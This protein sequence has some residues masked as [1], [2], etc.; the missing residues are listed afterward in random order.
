M[1]KL[2]LLRVSKSFSEVRALS[3]VSLE[4][5]SGEVHALMGENGAGKS[6]LIKI[7][8]GVLP[9]DKISI[10]VDGNLKVINSFSDSKK[11]GF[12]FIHQ[13]LNV[14]PH[15]SV[16]ENM[17]LSMHYPMMYNVFIN[18][19]R[20]H[21]SANEALNAL[22][23][24]HINTK[25]KCAQLS[26]GDQ[27]LMRIA[28]CLV[29]DSD[30]SPSLYVFD[31]PTAAL[32]LN[33]SEKLFQVIENLKN[34]GAAILY[35]SHRIDEV[36]QIS[37]RISVLRDG[38]NVFSE[39][40]LQTS[41]E[42]IITQ[43]TGRKLKDSYP[44]RVSKINA[45][46]VLE[47]DNASTKKINEINFKLR[48]GEILGVSG[49]SNSGQSELLHMMLGVDPIINGSLKYLKNHFF[50]R[51]PNDAWSNKIAF[52]PRE[53]RKEGLMLN[54]SIIE[55]TVISLHSELSKLYFLVDNKLEKERSSHLSKIVK[56]KHSS[57]EQSVYQLSGGNQQKVVFSRALGSNPKLLLLDEPTR[58]VD[59][60]A[61]FD[62]YNLIRELSKKGCS[63]ILN[64]SDL[65]EILGMC[66]RILIMKDQRQKQILDNS[67]LNS[68]ILLTSFYDS[69]VA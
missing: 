30:I 66:D 44:E 1:Y 33:E 65:S 11:L 68:K 45:R 4:L 43:M 46:T 21:Q 37:D 64:S 31:E 41:K 58:G 12:K 32:T 61:K 14:I 39:S 47:V 35:V 8:A 27:M 60:G 38:K 34:K 62:I 24:N 10:K 59:V 52:V 42:K 53:R 49:L 63:I 54:M 22:G 40:K 51:D 69:I 55:N 2:E 3:D 7:L 6:T 16:S 18:W 25:L 28:S 57:N 48:E 26:P 20:L 36:L 9:A 17:F 23:I 5:V 67:N 13:E 19:K 29:E 15:L 56:L 50:P